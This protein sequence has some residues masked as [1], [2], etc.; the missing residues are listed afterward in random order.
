MPFRLCNISS[1]ESDLA[2]FD[3]NFL[4]AFDCISVTCHS[5]DNCERL[6]NCSIGYL[7]VRDPSTSSIIIVLN[8]FYVSLFVFLL[9][10]VFANCIHRTR[11]H[12]VD[13]D[14]RWNSWMMSH[15]CI[16]S[17]SPLVHRILHLTVKAGDSS[18][19]VIRPNLFRQIFEN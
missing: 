6:W 17:I 19:G 5:I 12:S 11:N 4:P 18:Y 13:L 3:S 15:N 2:I 16:N 8:Y 9:F 14:M 7:P 1:T 10:Y